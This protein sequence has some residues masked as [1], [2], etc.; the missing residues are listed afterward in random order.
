MPFPALIAAGTDGKQYLRYEALLQEITEKEEELE[1][2][3][4]LHGHDSQLPFHLTMT[5]ELEEMNSDLHKMNL[6]TDKQGRHP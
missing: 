4:Q 1:H 6:A 5:E 2:C 3:L